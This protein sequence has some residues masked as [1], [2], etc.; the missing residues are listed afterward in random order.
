M[1]LAGHVYHLYERPSGQKYFSMLSQEE[2]QDAPHKFLGSFRLELDQSW[3]PIDKE[4][5]RFEG[6][7]YLKSM[8]LRSPPNK[9]SVKFRR[10]DGYRRL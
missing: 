5:D 10:S 9:R 7:N 6:I 1:Q 2:W 3:T 8:F 4:E